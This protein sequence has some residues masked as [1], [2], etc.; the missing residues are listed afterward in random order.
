MDGDPCEDGEMSFWP[1]SGLCLFSAASSDISLKGFIGSRSWRAEGRRVEQRL[2]FLLQT[3]FTVLVG[4][5]RGRATDPRSSGCISAGMLKRGFQVFFWRF[6]ISPSVCLFCHLAW[7]RIWGINLFKRYLLQFLRSDHLPW[8]LSWVRRAVE[9]FFIGSDRC[10]L[11][12]Y[13]VN[14]HLWV[15]SM[16]WAVCVRWAVTLCQG[17]QNFR[18]RRLLPTTNVSESFRHPSCQPSAEKLGLHFKCD[19]NDT[20]L[21]HLGLFLFFLTYFKG[22]WISHLKEVRKWKTKRSEGFGNWGLLFVFHKG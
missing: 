18:K 1:P 17:M 3:P 2:G 12:I 4:S 11:G 13:S 20:F 8:I 14:K 6:S 15:S 21:E 19:S 10:H 9:R 16:C 7:L 22:T 5:G